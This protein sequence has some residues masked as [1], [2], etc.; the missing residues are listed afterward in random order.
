VVVELI[1]DDRR[2]DIARGE[3]DV[4]LRAGSRPEGAGVV[5]KRLSD[6]GWTAYCSRSYAEER[7]IPATPEAF[8]GHHVAL[9]EGTMARV[10]AFGWLTRV[11][12]HATVNTRSN[13]LT[14]VLSAVKAGLGISMFPCII[15]DAEADLVR[16][17]PPPPE[18][19]S[20]VWLVIRENIKQAPH[21]RAFVDCLAAHMFSLR[22]QHAGR[23][24]AQIGKPDALAAIALAIFFGMHPLAEAVL[25]AC[26]A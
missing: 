17:L 22:D 16:C 4:A 1:T 23:T 8:A 5:A 25:S 2:L 20:E 7:G 14:N 15:G 24:P 18:L 6:A 26:C 21:V 9:V 11:A 19:D 10:P 3:A 12:E 13:S